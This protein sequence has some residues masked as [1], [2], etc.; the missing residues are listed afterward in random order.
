M[1]HFKI[2]QSDF[3]RM[4][5]QIEKEYPAD[6]A[7]LPFVEFPIAGA[8]FGLIKLERK[9]NIKNRKREWQLIKPVLVIPDLL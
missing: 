6:E 1:K 7:E 4:M 5:D 2:Y 9:V 8:N 3:I